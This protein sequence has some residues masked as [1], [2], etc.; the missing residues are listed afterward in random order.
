[1]RQGCRRAA[2]RKKL[3]NIN[4]L[5]LKDRCECLSRWCLCTCYAVEGCNIIIIIS[6]FNGNRDTAGSGIGGRHSQLLGTGIH[7][8]LTEQVP[9]L[10]ILMQLRAGKAET[11]LYN[12]HGSFSMMHC[13]GL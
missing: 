12:A 3:R 1:M 6:Y 2:R 7:L 4:L 11:A 5:Q 8:Y 10:V 13:M 9:V